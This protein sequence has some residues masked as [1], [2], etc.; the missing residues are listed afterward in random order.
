RIPYNTGLYGHELANAATSGTNFA[1]YADALTATNAAAV[2]AW[3][4]LYKAIYT[5]NL[6]IEGLT[7]SVLTQR[8][9]L[10]GEA[11]F[12]RAFSNFYLT[13]LYGTIPLALTSDYATNNLLA[14]S[15][16]ADVY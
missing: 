11:Y 7:P 3:G 10:L 12:L 6:V 8:N 13:N 4:T 14:R 15:P 2:T 1:F 9:Q 16:Q 5:C